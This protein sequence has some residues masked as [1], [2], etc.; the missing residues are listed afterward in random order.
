MTDAL[1]HIERLIKR[2]GS[3]IAT[4]HLTLDVQHGELHALIGPNGAGKT[5]LISQIMGE[6]TPD[7]GAILLDGHDLRG[8]GAAAR[9][10]RGLAR[11]FQIVQLLPDATALDNVTLAVQARQHR[12]FDI[13]R[14][15]RRD[16]GSRDD[17]SR[18][19]AQADIAHRAN[20]IVANLAHGE[21]KQLELALALATEPKLLLLDEPLAGLGPTESQRMIEIIASLKRDVT[22]LLVEH[23]MEAVYALADRISVLVSGRLIATGSAEQ[24]QADA[25]VRSAYLGDDDM[26]HA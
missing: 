25:S 21:Q 2:F 20:T 8:L 1:L 23:D 24:I 11:T 18:Y 16:E 22:I 7:E 17:A 9:T 10:R 15:A 26:G 14:N 4:D 13:W 19:L 5:T 3:L 12:S 6:L